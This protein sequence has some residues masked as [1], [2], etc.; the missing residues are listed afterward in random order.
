MSHRTSDI[1]SVVFERK[2]WSPEKARRW[3]NEHGYHPIK[4]VDMSHPKQYRY[5]LV[6]PRR[7]HHFISKDEPGHI[8]LVIGFY[9]PYKGGCRSCGGI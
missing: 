8:M 3:L 2:Y 4:D 6:D 1:Q 9:H 7:F 5:R